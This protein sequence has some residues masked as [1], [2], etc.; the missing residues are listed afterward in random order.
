MSDQPRQERKPPLTP[1]QRRRRARIAAHASWAKT[2]D[3]ADR[4]R[5]GTQAFLARFEREVDPDSTLPEDV[6]AKLA[7]HA[8]MAYMLRLAERSAAV[9]RRAAESA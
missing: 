8:K 3:R 4:T 1:E 7:E 2:R 9:R 6:R 5:A